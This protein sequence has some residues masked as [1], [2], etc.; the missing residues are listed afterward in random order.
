ML[1]VTEGDKVEAQLRFGVSVNTYGVSDLVVRVDEVTD[2]E[3]DK[4]I[5][6]YADKYEIVPELAPGGDQ[7]ESLR[8]GA[9]IEAGLRAFLNDGGFG[10]FTTNFQVGRPSPAS[11][12]GGAAADEGLR[13]RRRGRLEDLGDVAIKAMGGDDSRGTSF[14]EDY[15]YHW[16]PG[17]PKILGAHMLEVCPSIAVGRPRVEIHPLGIGDREDPVRLV[18]DAEPGRPSWSASVILE[19]D[20]GWCS[21]RSR[22]SS[23]TS[24]CLSYRWLERCGN[25]TRISPPRRSAG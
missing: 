1:R 16:G 8:Y 20:S 17:T 14:M 5:E 18:F 12:A 15:T 10:A 22:S 3:V 23:R 21:T 11:R 19:I 2:A 9:R 24:R 25:R 6:Q 13:L 7:H 4:L